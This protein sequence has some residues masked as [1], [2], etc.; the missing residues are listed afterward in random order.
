[1]RPLGALADAQ[2]YPLEQIIKGKAAVAH[3][4]GERLRVS[5]VRAGLVRSDCSGCGIERHQHAWA[6]RAKGETSGDGIAGSREG[7]PSRQVKDDN[8]RLQSECLKW[9]DVVRNAQRLRRHI[10]AASG[11]GIYRYEIVVSPFELEPISA[12]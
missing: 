4:L 2:P 6:W 11:S 12:Q 5:S 3:H 9:P 8:A 10:G 7:C 1:M